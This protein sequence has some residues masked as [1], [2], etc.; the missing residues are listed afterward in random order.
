MVAVTFRSLGL[1]VALLLAIECGIWINLAIPYFTGTKVNFIGYL[2][3]NTVQLGATIDYG[4][5]LTSHYLAHRRRM[6]ARQAVFA[7]LGQAFPSILVSA[8]ILATAGFALAV[9]SS[10]G[11]VASLGLLLGRGALISLGM[12]TCFLPALL[13]YGDGLIRRTTWRSGFF[14]AGS[15]AGGSASAPAPA[16]AVPAPGP[17]A[18]RP[19]SEEGDAS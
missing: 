6:P 11:A 7:A 14:R 13:V 2:V 9:S 3:V 12:V 15:G 19:F 17:R 8:G 16:A 10:I 5:L 18:A 4:I 1:P